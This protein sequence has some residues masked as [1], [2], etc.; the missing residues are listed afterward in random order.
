[1]VATPPP[2]YSVRVG[3]GHRAVGVLDEGTV[4]WYW[5]GSHA[6]YDRLLDTL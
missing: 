5:V 1:M 3:G 2:T 4:V 6:D